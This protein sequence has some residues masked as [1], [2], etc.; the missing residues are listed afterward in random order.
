MHFDTRIDLDPT[1]RTFLIAAVALAYP[2]WGAGFEL[3]AYG[4]LLYTRKVTAWAT[5]TGALLALLLLPRRIAAIAPLQL[6]IL[7]VPSVWFVVAATLSTQAEGHIVRPF[8]FLVAAASYL[9]CLPY[10]LYLVVNI[11]N[12]DILRLRGWRP[13]AG[14]AA[15]ALSFLAF[16]YGVGVR[17]DLF[18]T[19]HDFEL[20]GS[21]SPS[22]C[23]RAD[24]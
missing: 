15:V 21:M 24:A 20:A 9:V 8:L 7:A 23:R 4:E 16:G 12:P 1:A 11:V 2:V 19:C 3:G 22:G 17:N 6:L 10:A 5:V 14:L 18:M 13:K